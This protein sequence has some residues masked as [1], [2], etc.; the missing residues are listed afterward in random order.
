VWPDLIK[1]SASDL[2]QV[3]VGKVTSVVSMAMALLVSTL[4]LDLA[5][6]AALQNGLVLQAL[7]AFVCGLHCKNVPARAVEVGLA[8]GLLTFLVLL[9]LWGADAASETEREPGFW[10]ALVNIAAIAA[11]SVVLARKTPGNPA[12]LS[13]N[14]NK[15][16]AEPAQVAQFGPEKLTGAFIDEL[17]RTRVLSEPTQHP[18]LAAGSLGFIVVWLPVW[19]G[20]EKPSVGLVGGLPQWSMSMLLTLVAWALFLLYSSRKWQPKADGQLVGDI[21]MQ[22]SDL[23]DLSSL[24]SRFTGEVVTVQV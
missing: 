19:F 13:D 8:L 1:P 11:A 18:L 7:P 9:G 10:G 6:L 5:V 12:G 20:P 17:M 22:S 15:E 23:A 2:Q 21:Q 3:R 4:P 24:E 14:P 16:A